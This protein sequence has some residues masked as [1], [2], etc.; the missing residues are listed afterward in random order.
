MLAEMM[1]RLGEHPDQWQRVKDD[2]SHIPAVV[3][4][5]LRL[6]TPVQGMFRVVTHDVEIGGVTLPAGAR[7]VLVYASANR[8]D[9]MFAE[10]D[11]F[12]PDRDHLGDHVAFG[13]GIHHCLGANL[14]R[15]EGHVALAELTSRLRSFT[16]ADT[17]DYA[18]FPSFVLRGLTRLDLDI[19]PEA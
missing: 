1:R 16:L 3:D 19:V 15:L 4:E 8:D 13:R 14:A 7:V 17:N 6:G 12:D 9:A 11:T 2:P 5:A 18:V 10:P